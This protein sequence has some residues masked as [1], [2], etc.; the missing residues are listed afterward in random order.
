MD[1]VSSHEA[2]LTASQRWMSLGEIAVGS[3]LVI[4]HNVF[5]IVPNEVPILFVIGWVSL[6]LRDGG[7]KAVGLESP[8]SWCRTLAMALAA[9][10][11][12][13]L[14][15]AYVTDPIASRLWR[16]SPNLSE[17]K[18]LAGNLKRSLA[19]LGVIWTFAAF[20]EEMGY[21]GY[22]LARAADVGGRSRAAYWTAL[23]GVSV[24][25]GYGHYYQGPAGVLDSGFAGLIL[26]GAYLLSRR[27]LW[28]AI[29]AHGFSDT[30]ALIAVFLGW[31]SV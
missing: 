31:A 23:V 28:V 10:A 12:L 2:G 1:S 4:G 9:A 15:S 22:L 5:H 26:G 3:F 27:N 7:W 11:L 17:F 30:F 13:Q 8:P 21:R 20:G 18:P 19:G 24:L 14:G 16:H 25:F 6:R 29:L